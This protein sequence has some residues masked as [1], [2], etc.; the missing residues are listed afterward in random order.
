MSRISKDSI[1]DDSIYDGG[2]ASSSLLMS[3][4]LGDRVSDGYAAA[5]TLGVDSA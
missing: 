2:G 3:T 4:E 5:T 1:Y